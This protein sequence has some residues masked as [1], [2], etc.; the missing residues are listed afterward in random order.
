MVWNKLCILHM[1]LACGQTF[2]KCVH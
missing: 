2:N 1:S